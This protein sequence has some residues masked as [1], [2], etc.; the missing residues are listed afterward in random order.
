MNVFQ[1]PVQSASHSV[2]T[3][4]ESVNEH[5]FGLAQL[6]KLVRQLGIQYYDEYDPEN[7]GFEIAMRSV[8]SIGD[9]LPL[10]PF[11][12]SVQKVEA[13]RP[14]TASTGRR[15][16]DLSEIYMEVCIMSHPALKEHPN[17]LE[18]FGI[19]L[20]PSLRDSL[21]YDFG[22]VTAS[23]HGTLG[24]LLAVERKT[25][26]DPRSYLIPWSER[27]DI[28]IQ[29]AE[30]LAALHDCNILHNN[31]QPSSFTIHI[32]NT[33]PST[34]KVHVKLS[35]FG[36][37]ISL[38]PYT[39]FDDIVPANGQWSSIGPLANC[40]DSPFC[41]DIHSFG[42]MVMYMCYYEFMDV[43]ESMDFLRTQKEFYDELGMHPA[44]NTDLSLF[45]V[46]SQCCISHG[47]QPVTMHWVAPTI[48][49]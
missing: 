32:S 27:E 24:D 5:Q 40:V 31:V 39:V 20:L 36:T 35:N 41:R 15:N 43:Q 12:T 45:L 17:I 47:A 10:T 29:C 8:Q 49:K 23:T 13:K 7:V 19:T 30:G 21:E 37:A 22:L 44:L 9:R 14:G 4:L 11:A 25:S 6:R 3:A 26:R 33:S 16:L 18:L 34:R 38:T 48:R 2:Q 46:V 42:L 28:A 1:V